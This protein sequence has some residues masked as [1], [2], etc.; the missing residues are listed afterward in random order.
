MSNKFKRKNILLK[1][2]KDLI[3]L[4]YSDLCIIKSANVGLEL[5]NFPTKLEDL[6]SFE[7]NDCYMFIKKW[8]NILEPESL[9]IF[10]EFKSYLTCKEKL[11]KLK[12]KVLKIIYERWEEIYSLLNEELKQKY[13]IID[14]EILIELTKIY[15][16]ENINK[17]SI[18]DFDL[19]ELLNKQNK[20]YNSY[21][22]VYNICNDYIHYI[23]K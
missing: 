10:K 22:F 7:L 19:L 17:F 14:K 13:T 8:S 20:L 5:V 9:K 21:D 23:T 15:F 3:C 16:M 1:F 2:L 11:K 4:S 6:E 12:Q 18:L